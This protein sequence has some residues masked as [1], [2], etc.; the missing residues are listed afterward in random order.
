[1]SS[2]CYHTSHPGRNLESGD[3]RSSASPRTQ[4]GGGCDLGNSSRIDGGGD[5]LD[6]HGLSLPDGHT[7]AGRAVLSDSL[8]RENAKARTGARVGSTSRASSCIS[9]ENEGWKTR[10]TLLLG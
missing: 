3:R 1:M 2:S 6:G 4:A 5:S 10:R 7:D 8:R 9:R